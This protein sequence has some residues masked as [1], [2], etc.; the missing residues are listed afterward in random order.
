MGEDSQTGAAAKLVCSK[1]L[2]N[3]NSLSGRRE[4]PRVSTY[5]A[6]ARFKFGGGSLRKERSAADITIGAA[7]LRGALAAFAPE[8][9]IPALLRKGALGA[10][11][12]DT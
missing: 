8:A 11:G 4:L 1:C 6:S 12:G 3:H 7:G 2:E 5:P 10:P 9:G